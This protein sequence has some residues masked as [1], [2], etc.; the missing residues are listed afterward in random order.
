MRTRCSVGVGALLLVLLVGCVRPVYEEAP[1]ASPVAPTLVPTADIF[2]YSP[3]PT[4]QPTPAGLPSVYLEPSVVNLTV[5]E[6]ASVNV[7]IEAARGLNRF[8]LTLN[9]NSNYVQVE[10]ADPGRPGVQIAPGTIPAPVEVIQNEVTVE[11]GQGRI[12]YEVAQQAGTGADGNGVAATITLRG[13]ADGGTPL[14]FESVAAYDPE[15]NPVA[16]MPLSD[17]LITVRSGE[18]AGP[19]PT[20]AVGPLPSPVP[21]PQPA[22]AQPTSVPAPTTGGGIYYVVQPGE[23]LFRIG[24]KFGTTAQAIAAATGLAD[25]NQVEAGTMVLVPVPPPHGRYGYYVQRQDTVYSIARRFGMSVEQL[26]QL[27]GLGPDYRIE[28]GDILTVT[29]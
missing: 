17:G 10:D 25:P 20:T 16:L 27:N 21:T 29:P 11:Q 18:A 12:L 14:R 8:S 2:G 7:W 15:G 19:T 23:N 5:G 6:M 26:T 3:E 24:L 28:V 4:P 13:L 1:T 22:P 9:F